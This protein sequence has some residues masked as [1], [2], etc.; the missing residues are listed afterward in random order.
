MTARFEEALAYAAVVH[1]AQ[2]RKGPREIPYIGHLLGVAALVFEDGGD[3]DEA[4]AALLH[5]APED[6]GGEP[7]LADIR[8]RFGDRVAYILTGCSDTFDDPKPPWRARKER[9]LAHLET[10]EP[11]VLRVSIADKVHNLATTVADVRLDGAA[12]WDRFN[13]Q[14]EDQLW[15]YGSLLDVLRR[16]GASARL[17]PELDRLVGELIALVLASSPDALVIRPMR[18]AERASVERLVTP[19]L[20]ESRVRDHESAAISLLLA[21]LGDE[22]VGHVLVR[23]GTESRRYAALPPGVPVLEALGVTERCRNRGIGTALMQAAEGMAAGRGHSRLVLS[24]GVENHGARRLYA[25]RGYRELALERQY[26]SWTFTDAGGVERTEG[27]WVTWF[28][29]ELPG[30]MPGLGTP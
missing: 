25:R 12:V 20:L 19:F 15:Y 8:A 27:E 22:P 30:P 6:Q 3:E 28:E 26:L 24:V 4:I 2:R 7:R 1:A 29:R 14:A 21:W 17:V 16:R 13:A 23:W 10:A 11:S 18:P 5:D 9:Y